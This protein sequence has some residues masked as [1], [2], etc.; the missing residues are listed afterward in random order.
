MGRTKQ[1]GPKQLAKV[2]NNPRFTRVF[3]TKGNSR[4]PMLLSN[5]SYELLV[6]GFERRG[7]TVEKAAQ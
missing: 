7:Y 5:A 4:M 1:E 3:V 2:V 6:A